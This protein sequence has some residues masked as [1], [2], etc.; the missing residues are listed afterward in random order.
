L[1]LTSAFVVGDLVLDHFAYAELVRRHNV[2]VWRRGIDKVPAMWPALMAVL[3]ASRDEM[4]GPA[5]SLDVSLAVARDVLVAHRDPDAIELPGFSSW[6][7]VRLERPVPDDDRRLRAEQILKDVNQS[8][9]HPWPEAYDRRRL[10]DM[11][12]SVSPI[13]TP[14][15]RRGIHNAIRAAGFESPP[16]T[17]VVADVIKLLRLY[18]AWLGEPAG[19]QSPPEAGTPKDE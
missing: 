16:L 6:G 9:E 5:R 10:L 19:D 2:P 13:L 7:E 8:L 1:D 18:D 17:T 14:E 15:V 4:L 3:E 11:L 12:T